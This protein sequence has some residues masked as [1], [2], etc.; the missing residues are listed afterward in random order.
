MG[1]G[2]TFWRLAASAHVADLRVIFWSACAV[3]VLAGATCLYLSFFGGSTVASNAGVAGAIA[4]TASLVMAWA[5]QKGSARLGVVD[6]FSCEIATICRITKIAR[7]AQRYVYLY[8]NP[9]DQ[10]LRVRA[11]E[12][13]TPIFDGNSKELQALDAR[14]IEPVTEFY[15]YQ[16]ALLDYLRSLQNL[17]RPHDQERD[18]REGMCKVIYMFFLMLESGRKA[19]GELLEPGPDQVQNTIM[20]LLS[21]LYQPP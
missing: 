18:W 1:K 15:T 21:E 8:G 14:V 13:Y 4:G 5:Y 20:I 17:E 6:L 12:H 19:V 11:Q 10:A 7:A 9:P 3:F 16:K 2:P